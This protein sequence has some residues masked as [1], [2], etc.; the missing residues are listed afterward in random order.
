MKRTRISA[1]ARKHFLQLAAVAFAMGS[2][3]M[4]VNAAEAAIVDERSGPTLG[5]LTGDERYHHEFT[6]QRDPAGDL[7]SARVEVIPLARADA[8]TVVAAGACCIGPLQSGPHALR[9][10]QG[11]QVDNHLIR[12]DRSTGAFLHFLA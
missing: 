10:T 7:L 3:G 5:T 8:F 9:I 1:R 4:L 2:E 11:Q 6:L 12:I